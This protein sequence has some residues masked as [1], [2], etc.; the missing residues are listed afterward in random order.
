M[1][2]GIEAYVLSLVH[3]VSLE[4]FVFIGS[5]IE[6]VIAPVPALAVMLLSGSLAALE[7]RTLVALIPL[8]II[9]ALGK[10]IGAIIVYYLSGKVGNVILSKFGWLFKVTPADIEN[11]GKKI[12]GGPRDYLILSACRALPIL[13]SSVVSIG[14]GVLQIPFKLFLITTF[15]GTI[16]RDGIFL[17]IGYRG[18]TM[19]NDF[20][21]STVSVESY[22]QM[23]FVAF[24]VGVIGYVY[25]KRR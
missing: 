8:A 15:V 23:G 25:Y 7:E 10:T 22:L 19:L 21:N 5:F 12:T 17:Y 24:L 1:F 4:T 2:S 6:E 9:A 20:A 13:P 18:T 11:L 16:V 3:V 14:C